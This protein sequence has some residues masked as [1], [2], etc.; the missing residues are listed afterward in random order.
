MGGILQEGAKHRGR[1]VETTFRWCMLPMVISARQWMA[2]VCLSA[3]RGKRLGEEGCVES[4]ARRLNLESTMR[5]RGRKP[6]RLPAPKPIKEADPFD[7]PI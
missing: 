1:A 4:V 5:P 3:Q 6:I 7:G 2:V